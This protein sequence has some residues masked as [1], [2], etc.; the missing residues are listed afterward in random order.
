MH[1]ATFHQHVCPRGNIFQW[2]PSFFVRHELNCSVPRHYN[3]LLQAPRRIN[4]WCL[5]LKVVWTPCPLR[6][7]SNPSENP[8]LAH[9]SAAHVG[10]PCDSPNGTGFVSGGEGQCGR[11]KE[12]YY[13]C[14]PLLEQWQNF[15]NS[16]TAASPS[17]IF[18]LGSLQLQLWVQKPR[19]QAEQARCQQRAHLQPEAREASTW[20][21]GN[22]GLRLRGKVLSPSAS[23]DKQP[24]SGA[25]MWKS[26][27]LK[28]HT[29]FKCFAPRGV[30]RKRKAW[31]VILLFLNGNY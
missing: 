24:L 13:L 27:T 25:Y 10:T 29:G 14:W 7:K 23:A 22:A 26:E 19:K 5:P 18:H 15:R 3:G 4:K 28:K 12:R 30:Y 1:Q 31:W 16:L 20:P 11:E 17:F 6:S 9:F 21:R 2:P 8:I